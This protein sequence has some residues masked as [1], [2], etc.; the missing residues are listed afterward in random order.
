MTNNR[1]VTDELARGAIRALLAGVRPPIAPADCDE[2]EPYVTV[3]LEAF[4][5]G[6]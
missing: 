3:L 2:W 5:Q 1:S 4:D 6:G